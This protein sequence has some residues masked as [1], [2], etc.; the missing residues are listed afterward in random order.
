MALPPA[1]A[2]EQLMLAYAAGSAS[3]FETL[4]DRHQMRLWR[5][6]FRSVG[7]SAATD[8]L[9]QDVWLR[10]AGHASGYQPRAGAPGRPVAR[11]TT[12][13][14]TLAR[15][16]VIDHLRAARP[17]VSLD[18]PLEDGERTVADTLAAPS[19][20][21][22]VRRIENR[23][24][25]AQLLAA[26]DALPLVQRDAFLLQ[27]EGEMSVLEIAAAT[28]VGAQTAKSRLRYA[29]AALRRAL[30]DMT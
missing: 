18:E 21:G 3:A 12:W 26:L 5:Y 30:E 4:Y 28:G 16:R 22:P 23:Q 8:D 17:S 9:A 25:A 11:F 15:N 7:D 20:F 24:Q 27:A 6:I 10:V 2:D 19:G 1:T 13:L 14:F 29:R